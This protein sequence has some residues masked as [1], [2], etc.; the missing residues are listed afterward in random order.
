M[1]GQAKVCMA[2]SLFMLVFCVLRLGRYVQNVPQP[3]VTGFSCGIGAMMFLT[4][5]CDVG[6][7]DASRPD[8]QQH[9][10]PE[11][12]SARAYFRD[13]A[14]RVNRK[15]FGHH[16]RSYLYPLLSESASSVIRRYSF[17]YRCESFWP[18]SEESRAV[19]AR[20]PEVCWV[21]VGHPHTC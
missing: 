21:L 10:V 5:R 2:A 19:A 15:P 20:D 11:L 8:V 6:R 12:A 3:V 1:A 7:E 16:L 18:A 14:Q 4:V 17:C 9:A 13:A